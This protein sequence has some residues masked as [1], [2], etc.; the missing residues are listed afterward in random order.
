[1]ATTKTMKRMFSTPKSIRMITKYNSLAWL[2][3]TMVCLG[4]YTIGRIVHSSLAR[5][6]PPKTG[7]RGDEG[8][9]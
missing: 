2:S 7:A 8:K 3:F 6:P 9:K 5:Q 4:G 1:M